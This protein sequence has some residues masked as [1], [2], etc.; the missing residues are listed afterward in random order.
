MRLHTRRSINLGIAAAGISIFT[1]RFAHA[2]EFEMREVHNQP[3]DSPLHRRMVQLWDAVAMETHGRVHVTILPDSGEK[4]GIK[5]PLPLLQSG[6]LEFFT[7]AGNGLSAL[8]PAA[9]VQ[10]TPFAFRDP[11][12]VYGAIDGDL[13]D[14]LREEIRAKGLYLLPA[15]CFENGIHQLTSSVRPIRSAA[16]IRGLKLRVPGSKLYQDFFR[17]LGADVHTLNLNRTHDALKAGEID[18]QDDPWDDV[19]FLKLYE[20]QKYG[21]QTNH[22]WSGYNTLA[23]LKRWQSMPADIQRSIETNTRKYV[24][25]QRADTDKLNSEL[26]ATLTRHGMQFNDADRA[27]FKPALA[28]FYPRWRDY[29][30]R[31]AWDLLVSH[32]GPLG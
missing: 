32:T 5:N 14:Y 20:F 3:I 29:I 12:Q 1:P 15:G 24:A 9:D 28:E 11:A 26:R 23:N 22:S 7:L 18:S 6:E 25:L 21:S 30:G 16:D 19:E 2:A 17:S 13:G 4:E 31:R 10:A 8:V 27:S